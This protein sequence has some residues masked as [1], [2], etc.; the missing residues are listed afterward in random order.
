MGRQWNE[1]CRIVAAAG[2]FF[3][4]GAGFFAYLA[5]CGSDSA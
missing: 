5:V 2:W 3:L 1:D 4:I